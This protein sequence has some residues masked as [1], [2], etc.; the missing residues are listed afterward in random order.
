MG[1]GE[2]ARQVLQAIPASASILLHFDIDVLNKQDMPAAYFPHTDGLSIT[3]AQELLGVL[4]AD[5]RVRIIEVAEYASLRDLDQS[6][7]S[8]IAEMLATALKRPK[9]R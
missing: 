2:A 3:E 4:L 5:S 7:A 8:Q 6:Y 9:G 1:P